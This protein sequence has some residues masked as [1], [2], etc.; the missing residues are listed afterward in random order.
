[1][2]EQ[3]TMERLCQELIYIAM[4][5]KAYPEYDKQ[6]Q[7]MLQRPTL[8]SRLKAMEMLHKFLASSQTGKGK[9]AVVVD[10]L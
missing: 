2:Q 3:T 8:S 10:D 9:G 4:G 1:M 5:E 6:G 7:E